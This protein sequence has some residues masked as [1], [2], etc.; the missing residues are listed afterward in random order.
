ML[1]WYVFLFL[2]G[3]FDRRFTEKRQ[4]EEEGLKDTIVFEEEEGQEEG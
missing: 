3:C 1:T 2:A 4:K